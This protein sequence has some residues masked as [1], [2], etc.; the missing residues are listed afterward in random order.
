MSTA[1]R[2]LLQRAAATAGSLAAQPFSALAAG[3]AESANGVQAHVLRYAFPTAETTFDPQQV[4]DLYSRTV[5][6]NIFESLYEYDHLARPHKVRPCL[7]VALPEV[8]KDFKVYTVRLRRGVFFQDDPAFGGRPR[9]L[10]AADVVYTFK[11][12]VDPATRS[13]SLPNLEDEGIVGLAELRARVLRDKTPLDYDQPVAGLQALDRYTVRFTL[14]E[15]RPRFLTAL[16]NADVWGVMAREVVDRY[17]E[18]IGEHPV[19]TGPFRLASWRRSSRIVLERNPGYRERFY[20]AEPAADDAEGLALLARFK[21]R[22]L[23]MLERVEI[24]VIEEAQ[25]R[26]LS[27]LN[28]EQDLLQIVPAEF[29]PHALPGGA[30]APT[31]ARQGVRHARVAASDVNT[32]IFNMDSPLVGGLDE[33]HVALR[34]AI[35]TGYDVGREIRIA[36]RGE[37]IAAHGLI[38]PGTYGYQAGVHSPAT[39]FDRARAR[40]LLD[41]Y[42]Y[43]DRNGDGWRETPDGEPLVLELLAQSDQASRALD[44]V[45]KASMD[46]L[47]LKVELR[48]GQWSENLKAT[49]AGRFMIWRVG[50]SASSPDGQSAL[51]RAYGGSIGKGNLARFSLPAYDEIFRRLQALPDGPE[52]LALMRQASKLALA[53]MPYRMT[54]HRMVCDLMGPQLVGYRRP[55]F[56][57]NWWKMVDVEPQSAAQAMPMAESAKA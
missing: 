46:A 38:V 3:P 17:G 1:R 5:T 53:Y 55:L 29:I 15:G 30:L 50:S 27:F 6:A 41:L 43:L 7:A 35:S 13:P 48:I 47:G 10:T 32:L 4:S 21:G 8:S 54:V 42:G 16:T 19:G 18:H 12:V 57:L 14:R 11:R 45:F 34:R 52:R 20:E 23:P 33:A 25:P 26:W 36:R 44:E 2:T 56:W 24:A 51:E 40:A 22:R 49:R 37:A 28:H 9:E 31:L 39:L